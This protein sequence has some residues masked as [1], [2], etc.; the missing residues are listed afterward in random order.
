M[1]NWWTKPRSFGVRRESTN[2][3]LD[4]LREGDAFPHHDGPRWT[5][6]GFRIGRRGL[7][8]GHPALLNPDTLLA[9]SGPTLVGK[10]PKLE[11]SGSDAGI[12]GPPGIPGSQVRV[13]LSSPRTPSFHVPVRRREPAA[14]EPSALARPDESSVPGGARGSRNTWVQGI[15]GPRVYL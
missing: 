10:L 2:R 1:R 7:R 3:N 14:N 13:S 8:F 4:I 11:D 9:V 5:R 12:P 6:S 15:P